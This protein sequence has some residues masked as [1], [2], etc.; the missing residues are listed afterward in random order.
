MVN[1]YAANKTYVAK[2]KD[3]KRKWHLIDAEGKILGRLACRIASILRGKDKP[4]YTPHLD[5]G[6]PVIV[7]NAAKIKVTGNKLENKVYKRYSGYPSGLKEEKLKSLIAKKP[8]DVI[9]HAVK[10]M[11]PH[12]RLGRRMIKKLKVYGGSGHSHQAQAPAVL[13]V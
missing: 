10:G 2:E 11:L 4:I 9:Y 13:E 1:T 6:D 12:N 8:Q 5:T 3:I 7:I